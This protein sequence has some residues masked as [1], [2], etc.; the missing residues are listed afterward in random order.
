MSTPRVSPSGLGLGR[1][2]GMNP[3]QAI[4]LGLQFLPFLGWESIDLTKP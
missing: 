3:R 4:L 2:D 1:H